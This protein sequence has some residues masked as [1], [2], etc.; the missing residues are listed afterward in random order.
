MS[1]FH[2][3]AMEAVRGLTVRFLCVTSLLALT[4][5]SM[6][7]AQ[8]RATI[9]GA[10]VGAVAGTVAAAYPVFSQG[11]GGGSSSAL[12]WMA[13]GPV[14]GAIAGGATGYWLW[15]RRSSS[16]AQQL[17][18]QE[19]A[20]SLITPRSGQLDFRISGLFGF[21]GPGSIVRV[22]EFQTEGTG[23]HFSTMAMNKEQM[24]TI[25]IRYWFNELNALHF[26]FRYFNIGGTRFAG[27]PINFNGATIA[28]GQTLHYGPDKWF[29]GG[30]YYE[31]R[32]TPLYKS[33]EANWPT[34][35]KGWDLRGRIGIEFTYLD[36]EINGG[37][38]RVTPTSHGEET[39]EDFYHQSMPLPTIGLELYRQFFDNFI[40]AAEVE[41]NWI[42][43][44]NSL[45]DEGGTIWASQNGIEAHADVFYSNPSWWVPIQPM[46]GFFVYTYSQLEDSREDGNFIRWSSYGPEVGI[47]YETH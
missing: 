5:C 18:L 17:V 15:E 6:P 26:R 47:S 9:D 41:G 28:P 45:R 13:A 40:F 38:A 44:W 2:Q 16:P 1:H 32:L 7:A 42:N 43:R 14:L 39:K 25:D 23:L 8:R 19:S 10:A 12:A 11:A 36:F 46:I 20:P 3:A 31:R 21:T 4:S 27:A 34:L 22:R 35:L 29:S 37:K 24:P 33:H 30:L